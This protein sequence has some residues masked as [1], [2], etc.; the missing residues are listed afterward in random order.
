MPADNIPMRPL[1]SSMI[2]EAGTEGDNLI[3][4]FRTSQKRYSYAGAAHLLEHLVQAPSQGQYFNAHIRK[5]FPA[6]QLD[7]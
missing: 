6:T 1:S 2:D 7:E 3:V 5:E 4:R